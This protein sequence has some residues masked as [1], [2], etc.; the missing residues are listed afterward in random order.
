MEKKKNANTS[1]PES[2]KDGDVAVFVFCLSVSAEASLPTL[3]LSI[4]LFPST[5]H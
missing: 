2:C 1:T 4:S 3:F 5:F